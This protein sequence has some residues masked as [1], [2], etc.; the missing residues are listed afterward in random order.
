MT[1]FARF[2]E[3]ETGQR[4]ADHGAFHR[5]SV[6]DFRRFWAL[7]LRWSQPLHEGPT[8]PVCTD[9]R[10]EQATFFP[11]LRLNYVENLLR[12]D[13]ERTAD[14]PALTSHRASGRHERLTRGALR[15]RVAAAMV[16]L[17]GLGVAPGE[18]VAA[19][20]LNDADAVIG[21]LAALALGATLSTASPEMGAFSV[22]ER[23]AQLEP[24]VLLCHL[25][26]PDGSSLADR[27]AEIA[28]GLPSLRAV[29]ALDDG[30]APADLAVPLRTLPATSGATAPLVWRRFPFN[31]PLFILFS[32]GTTG[33]PKCIEHGA[34]GSL[35]EHTKEHRLHTDLRPSDKLFF[36]TTCSWMMWNWQLSA[37]AV[38]AEIVLFDGPIK[39]PET[40]WSLVAAEQV[41]VFGTSPAYLQMCEDAGYGPARS[42]PL[43]ALRAVLSTGSILHDHQFDWLAAQV[44]PLPLQSISGGTDILG[45]FV[46]GNPNLPVYRGESQGKSLGL[47]VEALRDDGSVA[48][49]GE[50]GELVCRN[51]FP[52][53]P[54][55]FHGDPS[56]ERFHA[57]YFA[58]HPG[59]WTHGDRIEISPD[60]TVRIHGRSDGILNVRGLR[61]GPAE[62]YRILQGVAEV[63]EALAVE[64]AAQE[65]HGQSRLVLLVVLRPGSTL[66]DGLRRRIRR[67][68]A[69]RG[70]PGHVP[71]VI[72]A[73]RELP[74]TPNGKRSERA[75]RDAING[76]EAPNAS[77]LRNPEILGEIRRQMEAEA[78]PRS[79][80]APAP[81][82]VAAPSASVAV[83]SV[84]RIAGAPSL[85]G[86]V[87]SVWER[88]LGATAL[89]PGDDFYE[90]GGTSL[91]ALRLCNEI[92]ALTGCDLPPSALLD[93]PTIA[94]MTG[95]IRASRGAPLAPIVPLKSTGRGRPLFIVHG[96]PGDILELRVLALRMAGD[97]PLLGLRARGLD[98]RAAPHLTVEEM[99]RDYVQIVRERQPQGPYAVAGYSFGGLVAYE[100]ARALRRLGERVE[101]VG[102]L[103]TQVHD[104]CLPLPERLRFRMLRWVHRGARRIPP[105]WSL[106]AP[107][108]RLQRL[109]EAR[110]EAT[111][112]APS[113]QPSRG[114]QMTPLMMHLEV[115]AWEAFRAYRPGPYDGPVTFFQASERPPDY[116]S[117]IPVWLQ[118]TQGRLSISRVPGD[119]FSMMRDPHARTLA[120]CIA[121]RL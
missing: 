29:V 46:L 65:A 56:G 16:V 80:T 48:A 55:G 120:G 39:G 92:Q 49:P 104:A 106:S 58:Q 100:M 23:F 38:G 53:R 31:H 57:S 1:A 83:P 98:P 109:I 95:A 25:R 43:G 117:P 61:I 19:V 17:E 22:V 112:S 64:Q 34:G 93:A 18:R 74:V 114:E 110:L 108:R 111:C 41:T 30:P 115:L 102:L 42:L 96:L 7:F 81:A 15:E 27:V 103:D 75:A 91:L 11:S 28:R 82:A 54:L 97:R 71:D 85:E 60:E 79:R 24:V 32:S 118:A 94:E 21:A 59:V 76:V 8:E 20:V 35:L 52:S 89:A 121:A 5:F 78:A 47:D 116:C 105:P 36:H 6:G 69:S 72:L 99:A 101:F 13:D 3:E 84:A 88:V 37:L 68:L 9:D 26:A 62:I 73:V 40:L 67:E 14:R 45:C 50:V 86:L 44:G 77:A 4:F 119:H 51:P 66:D 10:C 70:S 2:C 90:L 12:I 87:T 107:P 113:P 33:R 63:R